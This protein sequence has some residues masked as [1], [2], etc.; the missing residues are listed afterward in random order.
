MSVHNSNGS[1]SPDTKGSL[2]FYSTEPDEKPG[3]DPG[4]TS[5]TNT[6][7]ETT[8]KSGGTH[9]S[10]TTG[11]T[12]GHQSSHQSSEGFMGKIRK[13]MFGDRTPGE[14]VK[15]AFSG[16]FGP[17]G[18][19]GQLLTKIAA[20][21]ALAALVLGSGL[22]VFSILGI[23]TTYKNDDV[24]RNDPPLTCEQG[25]MELPG[26]PNDDDD[27]QARVDIMY[28][29]FVNQFGYSEEFLVGMLSCMKVE[30]GIDP[31][32][33]ESD[34]VYT[35]QK[36]TFDAAAGPGL[37]VKSDTALAEYWTYGQSFMSTWNGN[38]AYFDENGNMCCGIGLI[39]WTGPRGTHM[40][41]G[42]DKVSQDV[43]PMDLHYQCAWML[44]EFKKT[45][46]SCDT[47][48]AWRSQCGSDVDATRFF[49]QTVVSGGSLNDVDK[50]LANVDEC[51]GYVNAAAA[52][53][54]FTADTVTMAEILA[55]DSFT[56]AV[57][58]SNGIQLCKNKT[59]IDVSDIA[60]AA[61]SISW[62]ERGDYEDVHGAYGEYRRS[63]R[64]PLLV[65]NWDFVE[66]FDDNGSDQPKITGTYAD[67]GIPADNPKST[68]KFY[69]G[70]SNGGKHDLIACTEY[71]YFAHLICFPKETGRSGNAGYFSSCDR[72]TGTAVRIA[73]AD[74]KFPAGN[75]LY[76]LAHATGAAKAG[77]KHNTDDRG[78]QGNGFLWQFAGFLRGCDYY[79][80]SG[81][82]SIAPGTVM[83]SWSEKAANGYLQG[84]PS[85]ASDSAD[86]NDTGAIGSD[87]VADIELDE[88]DPNEDAAMREANLRWPFSVSNTTRHIITFVG[89][90]TVQDFWGMEWLM[91]QWTLFDDTDRLIRGD[92]NVEVPEIMKNGSSYKSSTGGKA[93]D[94]KMTFY[95]ANAEGAQDHDDVREDAITGR[96]MPFNSKTGLPEF[97]AWEQIMVRLLH[98]SDDDV[99]AQQGDG[100]G[101]LYIKF[102]K[103]EDNYLDDADQEDQIEQYQNQDTYADKYFFEDW[104]SI[105]AGTFTDDP[106][107]DY[108]TSLPTGEL[109]YYDN[110]GDIWTHDLGAPSFQYWRYVLIADVEYRMNQLMRFGMA[111][112]MCSVAS[113]EDA[114]VVQTGTDM[115]NDTGHILGNLYRRYSRVDDK[116]DASGRFYYYNT[117][118]SN[119]ML[120]DLVQLYSMDRNAKDESEKAF[121]NY[122]PM[123]LLA[124]SYNHG[125]QYNNATAEPDGTSNWIDRRYGLTAQDI[126]NITEGLGGMSMGMAGKDDIN[127]KMG[128]FMNVGLHKLS[129]F[130]LALYDREKRASD[131]HDGNLSHEG[132]HLFN[133]DG[134]YYASEL[135]GVN[136]FLMLENDD[137]LKY[138]ADYTA[139]EPDHSAV[140]DN[141]LGVR[142]SIAGTTGLSG[143]D[144]DN[145]KMDDRLAWID[146]H[147]YVTNSGVIGTYAYAVLALN[148]ST[149]CQVDGTEADY[150]DALKGVTTLNA[151]GTFGS[152]DSE[153]LNGSRGVVRYTDYIYAETEEHNKTAPYSMGNRLFGN[154]NRKGEDVTRDDYNRREWYVM[155]YY[156]THTALCSHNHCSI[157][158]YYGEEGNACGIKIGP[159]SKLW[160]PHC[161]NWGN[162]DETGNPDTHMIDTIYKLNDDMKGSTD[163]IGDTISF[164]PLISKNRNKY[165][166]TDLM[167]NT[168]DVKYFAYYADEGRWKE[169]QPTDNPC[170]T[171]D[172]T[173]KP[174]MHIH[175]DGEYFPCAC[176]PGSWSDDDG[177][178]VD[179]T[180]TPG[181]CEPS[182]PGG[183]CGCHPCPIPECTISC[184]H[185]HTCQELNDGAPWHNHGHDEC[186]EGSECHDKYGCNVLEWLYH[187]GTPVF[188]AIPTVENP[189]ETMTLSKFVSEYTSDDTCYTDKG[190]FLQQI[191]YSSTGCVNTSY[192]W[193]ADGSRKRSL[194][195]PENGS[196]YYD[197][198]NWLP[199]YP[200]TDY[201]YL[202]G[203]AGDITVGY[204][205]GSDGLIGYF[206]IE[207]NLIRTKQGD[208]SAEEITSHVKNCKASD[209]QRV[210]PMKIRVG[211]GKSLTQT[212]Y[213][214]DEAVISQLSKSTRDGGSGLAYVWFDT[215][216]P[217]YNTDVDSY[218]GYGEVEV[219]GTQHLKNPMPPPTGG[220]YADHN[221]NGSGPDGSQGNKAGMHY[222]SLL[223]Q[224]LGDEHVV[225]V[226]FG[227]QDAA[228]LVDKDRDNGRDF[229]IYVDHKKWNKKID[230][231]KGEDYEGP[232]R[233]PSWYMVPGQMYEGKPVMPVITEDM[234][235]AEKRAAYNNSWIG[236]RSSGGGG[237]SPFVDMDGDAKY[238]DPNTGL[239]TP[240]KYFDNIKKE[241]TDD[242]NDATGHPN[243]KLVELRSRGART[244]TVRSNEESGVTPWATNSGDAYRPGIDKDGDQTTANGDY[245]L[246]VAH[247]SRGTRGMMTQYL[248]FKG[249]FKYVHDSNSGIN[250]G[251]FAYML[252]TNVKRQDGYEHGSEDADHDGDTK[253]DFVYS[254][255][256]GDAVL[257]SS[258]LRE[259]GQVWGYGTVE[260]KDD[261][262]NVIGYK[263][264]QF[265]DG[266]GQGANSHWK[267][268][269]DVYNAAMSETRQFGK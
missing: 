246:W 26:V 266:Y 13:A 37:I 32:R 90:G 159:S 113:E 134:D 218:N 155:P 157:T 142:D 41:E 29:I 256:P 190:N 59:F 128:T 147:Y 50:R 165:M 251:E 53:S 153:N 100:E 171:G 6:T 20:P 222:N 248:N 164:S 116:I 194:V 9:T 189:R 89:E 186:E 182:C 195:N 38:D 263:P 68:L 137:N 55:D 209:L 123:N 69:E 223:R 92:L 31:D 99:A 86:G 183:G 22:G 208:A 14:R 125:W 174:P 148:P 126:K 94:Q 16:F 57:A 44:S 185:S 245:R 60:K 267:N 227:S 18:S 213:D 49:F 200:D 82:S 244:D 252:F 219:T 118:V 166:I 140:A 110:W 160:R 176:P 115:S 84:E 64:S 103:Q 170:I 83:I 178:G 78:S 80:A 56:A 262:G 127:S 72:G 150:V 144:P 196:A 235:A 254:S 201:D 163:D 232:E 5:T 93:T 108:E 139:N 112:F 97:R 119:D 193:L 181:C 51:R 122:G 261:A 175:C 203:E 81:G 28:D 79:S 168:T 224:I 204:K 145:E 255:K 221:V 109:L 3:E 133:N 27:I 91:Q 173:K 169:V 253:E 66:G 96:N 233:D 264:A 130:E 8:T 74:D 77:A 138:K 229:M 192:Q 15:G 30:S 67:K 105:G 102:D 23:F 238:L 95:K 234:T 241:P 35:S 12:G 211:Y 161:H 87:D 214:G 212:V 73:G 146:R 152:S 210:E 98:N 167:V 101:Q 228:G 136:P 104:N 33:L 257:E 63:A 1:D 199:S 54:E 184:G 2:N 34:F 11:T 237:M 71:Y 43:S 249:F 76:Q 4:S 117:V 198:L 243:K 124:S 120:Q 205:D 46:K 151:T 268:L 48:G 42:L 197:S 187:T 129:E 135:Y 154:D 179:D 132:D 226:T 225:H 141:T 88:D 202:I 121:R 269:I 17:G 75:P 156:H 215:R 191:T 259:H 162:G 206:T 24:I 47:D 65:N 265:T 230:N 61:V 258:W 107:S 7:T 207:G 25:V 45:Y 149:G 188:M 239:P 177:D 70:G 106:E 242:E 52:N 220:Y 58:K 19:M 217:D 158:K 236:P 231:D 143:V 260:V 216:K 114:D 180:Y 111:S 172:N 62:L 240:K 85:G 21:K 39:Q 36:D 10:G 247:A 40:L 250:D 131:V